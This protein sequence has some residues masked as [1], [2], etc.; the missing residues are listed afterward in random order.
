[1]NELEIRHSNV[2]V[3]I[4]EKHGYTM[5]GRSMDLKS[6]FV[7]SPSG[8]IHEFPDYIKAKT[9]LLTRY[10]KGIETGSIYR[11]EPIQFN[12]GS[13][14][15]KVQRW[16]WDFENWSGHI[17]DHPKTRKQIEAGIVI[18]PITKEE[19]YKAIGYEKKNA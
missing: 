14:G 10:Y 6:V 13:Q 5:Q 4:L 18:I 12:D 11:T 1:M 17:H 8:K 15:L 9:S 19:A 3:K 7:S 16:N 2:C